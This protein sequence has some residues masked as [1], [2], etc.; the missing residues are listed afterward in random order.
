MRWVDYV[1]WCGRL[2][3]NSMSAFGLASK[4]TWY[5]WL[6]IM[7]YDLFKIITS[8]FTWNNGQTTGTVGKLPTA[9][10]RCCILTKEM[11]NSS[12]GHDIFLT[13]FHGWGGKEWIFLHDIWRHLYNS[14]CTPTYLVWSSIN[15]NQYLTLITRMLF[16]GGG[17]K[18]H[19]YNCTVTALRQGWMLMHP[20]R[21]TH[22]HEGLPT[23]AGTRYIM[24]TC[25][26]P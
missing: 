24:V 13:G 1:W 9:L 12:T 4:Y 2:W 17:V 19:R 15:K 18:F 10:C 26:D 21:L 5:V 3:S 25:V 11:V 22:I 7:L 20:G 14:V 8:H 23:T 6:D 16:Q